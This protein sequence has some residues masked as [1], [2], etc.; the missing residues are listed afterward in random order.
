M[1]GNT[2]LSKHGSL[3]PVISDFIF[4]DVKKSENVSEVLCQ[5][6]LCMFLKKY[7][8]FGLSECKA[9]DTESRVRRTKSDFLCCPLTSSLLHDHSR[10]RYILHTVTLVMKRNQVHSSQVLY[11]NTLFRY[12]HLSISIFFLQLYISSQLHLGDKYCAFNSTT[13]FIT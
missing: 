9:K 11:L 7:I 13:Y 5:I 10:L 8:Q 2:V 1:V 6:A 12:L 4:R 3:Q